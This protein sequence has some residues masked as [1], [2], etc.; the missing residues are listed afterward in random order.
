M[1]MKKERNERGDL[2]IIEL[3]FLNLKYT[4]IVNFQLILSAFGVPFENDEICYFKFLLLTKLIY[5]FVL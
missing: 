1:L 3:S 2:N 5:V 4:Y